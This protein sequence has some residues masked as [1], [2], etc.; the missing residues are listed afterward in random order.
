MVMSDFWKG[1]VV[2]AGL[3]LVAGFVIWM[4]TA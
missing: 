4:V 3:V 1:F 2:G